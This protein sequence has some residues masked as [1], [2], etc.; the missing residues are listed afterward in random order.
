PFYTETLIQSPLTLSLLL[1]TLSPPTLSP[2]PSTSSSAVSLHGHH[3]QNCKLPSSSTITVNPLLTP[4]NPSIAT[5]LTTNPQRVASAINA[6]ASLHE[7][8]T[9]GR[10]TR[11]TLR[12]RRTSGEIIFFTKNLYCEIFTNLN[13]STARASSSPSSPPLASSFSN[14]DSEKPT[15]EPQNKPRTKTLKTQCRRCDSRDQEETRANPKPN[16]FVTVRIEKRKVESGRRFR[17]CGVSL[18]PKSC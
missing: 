4:P 9:P 12:R 10:T 6:P 3:H 8:L 14:L 2:P 18:M 17:R 15:Q 13:H 16:C 11:T 1:P 5:I 7:L